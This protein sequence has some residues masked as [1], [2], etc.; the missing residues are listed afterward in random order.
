[1]T[2]FVALRA[3]LYACRQLDNKEDKKCERIK[4]LRCEENDYL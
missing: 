4:K 1:M 2:E 3:K